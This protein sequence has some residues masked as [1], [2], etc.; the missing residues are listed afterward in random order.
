M[1]MGRN[2][3]L[4]W[5]GCHDWRDMNGRCRECGMCAAVG[6]QTIQFSANLLPIL[7]LM[8]RKT[9]ATPLWASDVDAEGPER[10]IAY[11]P[12]PR[13]DE[14]IFGFGHDIEPPAL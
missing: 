11:K 6:P 3:F 13:A 1:G 4:C 14:A 8:Q 5:I 2:R 7:W 9:T 12:Y 10:K